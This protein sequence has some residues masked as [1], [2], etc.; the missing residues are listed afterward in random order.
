MTTPL[1]VGLFV[2]ALWRKRYS[3][4][5]LEVPVNERRCSG[6]DQ[7]LEEWQPK[8]GW[9]LEDARHNLPGAS[10]PTSLKIVQ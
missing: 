3:S 10:E 5:F 7:K 2:L 6:V 8:R 9:P 4:D 1:I